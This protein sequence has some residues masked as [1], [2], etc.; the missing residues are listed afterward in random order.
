M[1]F[2]Y[3]IW[4]FNCGFFKNFFSQHPS[5]RTSTTSS[6]H[7]DAATVSS[8]LFKFNNS[9]SQFEKN[10]K[11]GLYPILEKELQNITPLLEEGKKISSSPAHH[12]GVA[13]LINDTVKPRL[14]QLQTV[15]TATQ[16]KLLD[17]SKEKKAD[18][19]LVQQWE[20][21]GLPM[22]VL[23]DHPDCVRFLKES[24]L[25]F[26]IVGYRESCRDP[27]QHDIKLDHDG[28]PMLK[29]KGRFVRW[30]TVSREIEY[31][32]K[33]EKVKSRVY[34]GSIV[35]SWNYFQEGLVP[36]DR[37]EYDQV[38]PVYKLTEAEYN[39]TLQHARKFY[40]TH[41][42]KDPG[43]AKDCIVQ[44]T[45]I[46]NRVVPN[47][48]LFDHA[49]RNYPVHIGM[50]LITRDGQVYSFGYQ[51]LPEEAAFLFSD[52]FSTFLATA[53]AKISMRDYEEFR[54]VNKLVTS[55]PLSSQ[56]AQNILN[57][58]NELNGQQ[59][60][61]QYMRQNCSQLMREVM[62]IAGYDVDL[63]TT[64]TEVVY[65]ALPSLTQIPVIK[66]VVSFTKDIWNSLPIFTTMPI[67]F[68]ANLM[69]YIPKKVAIVATNLLAWKMG[70]SKKT[71]PLQEGV[72]DEVFYDKKKLQ[73]FSTLIRSW[74]DIFNE[75]TNVVYHSKYFIDWQKE[76]HSTF[77]DVYSK[78][79][80][81][82]IVPP[83]V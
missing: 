59:L 15:Y 40:E 46:E 63:R 2:N 8:W 43:I 13:S 65:D 48:A 7:I 47:G 9:F 71:T 22:S 36:V 55:I 1:T 31:D 77:E 79:P 80:K 4:P 72:E 81:F 32:S 83:S 27:N 70:A 33:S 41:S 37:F 10:A 73:T 16:K 42:E 44:F 29:M 38:F 25:V 52:Y 30:E 68:S 60:R 20:E 17:H 19:K 12:S 21:F 53:E 57:R 74:G 66:K 75:E 14:A 78:R 6:P 45:T 51:L 18:D 5:P 34:P 11:N 82:A 76:Q 64:G 62:Q 3:S 67:E 50:R 23:K 26:S 54:P 35:Q 58:L 56:R 28:H 39:R 61:F 69:L 24:G 49:Q